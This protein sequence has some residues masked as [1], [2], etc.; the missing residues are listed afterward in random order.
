V[1]RR[2]GGRPAASPDLRQRAGRMRAL[3]TDVD[4]TLTDRERRLDPGAI[5]ALRALTRRGWPVVL[6]TGNVLPIALAL[7]RSLGVN[8]PI[9]AENGGILY[10]RH[11]GTERVHRL[12]DRRVAVAAYRAARAHGVPLRPLFT[13]RWRETEV[14]LEPTVPVRTL[15][16]AV[17]GHPVTV[18]STGYALHLMEAGAGKLPALVRALRPI[19]LTPADCLIAGDGD[20]DV[21]MLRAAGVSVSFPTGSPR[22]RRAADYVARAPYALGFVEALIHLGVYAPT[23]PGP[24][25]G[26]AR[27]ELRQVR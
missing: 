14:G 27:R 13:D 6:A 26:D 5:A 9:V 2:R 3:V 18:E 7:H 25:G 20:N 15:A 16:R 21:A 4:G 8:G 24:G 23:D 22:A 10:D 12:S 11:D 17:R 19:G 1:T